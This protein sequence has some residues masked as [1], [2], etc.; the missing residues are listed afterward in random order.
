MKI[1]P[2]DA[3]CKG[4]VTHYITQEELKK[5][6]EPFEKIRKA[7]GD[8]I[9]I[10]VEVHCRWDLRVAKQIAKAPGPYNPFWFEDPI[11]AFNVEALSEFAHST[12]VATASSETVG[13]IDSYRDI[14]AAKAAEIITF[15]PT[16][17]GG[18]TEAKKIIGLTEVH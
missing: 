16:W 17:T 4:S 2:F 3:F 6:C 18:V 13:S 9:E 12:H 10:M 8:K 7:V 5:G 14:C 15:D 11:Q 1:W